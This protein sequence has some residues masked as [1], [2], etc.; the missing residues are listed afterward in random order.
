MEQQEK[1]NL[2]S[3]CPTYSYEIIHLLIQYYVRNII[4]TI[5]ILFIVLHILKNGLFQDVLV[6]GVSL[7]VCQLLVDDL[8]LRTKSAIQLFPSL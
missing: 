1:T 5:K 4:F 3:I 8:V 2:S 7:T 6:F